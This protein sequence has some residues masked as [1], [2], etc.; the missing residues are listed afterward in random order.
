MESV[1]GKTLFYA[2]GN[3]GTPLFARSLAGGPERKVLDFIGPPRDFPVFEDGIYYGG[4]LDKEGRVPVFF[5]QFSTGAS[6]L[7]TTIERYAQ[8]GLTVSPDRKTILYTRTLPAGSD[9][10]MIENFH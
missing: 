6:R 7:I 9:L 3:V 2:K 10:M 8:S 4:R 5:Y 1:D